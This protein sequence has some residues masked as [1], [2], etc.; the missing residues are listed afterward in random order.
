MRSGKLAGLCVLAAACVATPKE[1]AEPKIAVAGESPIVGAIDRVARETSV[2]APLLAAIAHSQT[3]FRMP[4]GHAHGRVVVGILGLPTGEALR[5]ARLAGIS[6]EAAIHDLEGNLRAGA[7]LLRDAA[8]TAVTLD[9]YLAILEPQLR[10]AVERSLERGV[11]A[12]DADG[13][14]ILL[15]ARPTPHSGYGTITQAA[16]YPGAVWEPAYSGNF[17]EANRG[18][19][20]ITN[21]VIHTTQGSFNGTISWFKDPAANVSAHYVVRSH[22]G[23]VVQMVSEK[24]IAW[25]DRCFNTT[26]IGIEHEG[27]IEDPELWYTEPMYIESA[28][29]VAYLADKY[30]LRKEFG[31]IVGHDTAPDCSTHTDP[32][33][34]WNWD[35]FIELVKTGGAKFSATDVVVSGPPT[36]IAGER[37]TFTVTVTNAGDTAWE[38]DVTR[39]GT[40]QPQDR[41]SELFT[42]GDWLSPSRP[43]G[44]DARVLPGETGTFSFDVVAPE[45]SEPTL[46]DETFQMV[47]EGVIWFG[48]DIHV[49]IQVLPRIEDE[50]PGGCNAGH[51]EP[52][53]PCM[54]A[55]GALVLVLRRRRR[56][57]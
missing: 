19:G 30:G 32:G 35:H 20:D 27:F 15:A 42:D 2:P 10:R 44:V 37:G 54:F 34:G 39:L 22:D 56:R 24:N 5:G 25:H 7:A 12:R 38:L 52:G 13:R 1:R 57:R 51:G 49:P 33:P 3:R 41:E 11:D 48:P 4:S 55:A 45:V 40:A 31:V 47:E 36:L 23:H 6:D 29:L 14:S 53:L 8:P 21:V 46:F 9:D 17:D 28:K 50:A 18:V 26:T 16:G 43:T